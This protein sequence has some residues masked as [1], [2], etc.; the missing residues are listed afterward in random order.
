MSNIRNNNP[1][2]VAIKKEEG[3][4]DEDEDD[5]ISNNNNNNNNKRQRC[6]GGGNLTRGAGTTT[7][8]TRTDIDTDTDNNDNNNEAV[9]QQPPPPP[10]PLASHITVKEW[11]NVTDLLFSTSSKNYDVNMNVLDDYENT[12][13]NNIYISLEKKFLCPL[14]DELKIIICNHI[15]VL[16]AN[17]NNNNSNNNKRCRDDND[18]DDGPPTKKAGGTSTTTTTTTTDDDDDDSPSL[19]SPEVAQEP[20]IVPPVKIKRS[21]SRHRQTTDRLVDHGGTTTCYSNDYYCNNYNYNNGGKTKPSTSNNDN[22]AAAAAATPTSNDDVF[23]MTVKELQSECR[24]RAIPCSRLRKVALVETLQSRMNSTA[25]GADPVSSPSVVGVGVAAGTIIADAAT[26]ADGV[27]RS[28]NNK[29]LPPL[30]SSSSSSNNLRN[31]R[32]GEDKSSNNNN[33]SRKK[34]KTKRSEA[35]QDDCSVLS[36]PYELSKLLC[37]IVNIKTTT[38]GGD[39]NDD[40]ERHYHSREDSLRTLKKLYRWSYNEGNG[41]FLKHFHRY[42]GMYKLLDFMSIVLND[43]NH[44]LIADDDN[45]NNNFNIDNYIGNVDMDNKILIDNMNCIKYVSGIIGCICC[46]ELKSI[47]EIWNALRNMTSFD[48]TILLSEKQAVMVLDSGIQM[49]EK[50]TN[51]T[52]TSCSTTSTA[53]HIADSSNNNNSSSNISI[54]ISG[55][56]YQIFG[57]FKNII[58]DDLIT[59][60]DFRRLNVVSKCLQIFQQQ[61]MA[62]T[63]EKKKKK[64]KGSSS[65]KGVVD[66]AISWNICSGDE[67]LTEVALDF[68]DGCRFRKLLSS[69]SSKSSSNDDYET[70]LPVCVITL[71][72]FG[73]TNYIIRNA[74][75][76][77]LE[78]AISSKVPTRKIELAGVK[79]FDKGI[80][81]VLS[82][83]R[84]SADID[85]DEKG[86]LRKLI[87]KIMGE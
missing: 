31:A 20:A 10:P 12:F 67:A 65:N 37:E 38:S 22:D 18:N 73:S 78:A 7:S 44:K 1:F 49:I 39:D 84:T 61:R 75:I 29:K 5:T 53:A 47:Q 62:T 24:K 42:A 86:R 17:K 35:E 51:I 33:D 15:K 83:I 87:F 45:N 59:K 77:L 34:K 41:K 48:D 4:V 63:M 25:I 50:L 76:E 54:M 9:E 72:E 74:V 32:Q 19:P 23:K 46:K 14:T 57:A 36:T 66:D 28:I 64:K 79:E 26:D 3:V 71:D 55:I 70:I 30:S 58:I 6:D 11:I 27:G 56:L 8:I 2:P 21:S 43:S 80:I 13:I 40:D 85:V 82:H 52:T 68:L 81:Q 16:I 60:K 69:S